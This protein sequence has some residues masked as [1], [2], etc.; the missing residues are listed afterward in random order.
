MKLEEF[1]NKLLDYE[2]TLKSF[3]IEAEVIKEKTLEVCEM[4]VDNEKFEN[5]KETSDIVD[6][7]DLLYDD[8]SDIF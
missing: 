4:I 1:N 2:K 6:R 7:L 8:I 3:K 5:E